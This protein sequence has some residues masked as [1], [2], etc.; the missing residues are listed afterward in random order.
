MTHMAD[1]AD[2]RED[3]LLTVSASVARDVAKVCGAIGKEAW[4]RKANAVAEAI[5]TTPAIAMATAQ[6]VQASSLPR[7]LKLLER[8][9]YLTHRRLPGRVPR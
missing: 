9:G 7:L 3:D 8:R 5:E 2:E 4:E 6:A 1:K